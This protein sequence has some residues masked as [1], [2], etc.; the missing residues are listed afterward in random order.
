MSEK[1][2]QVC[3]HVRTIE[4]TEVTGKTH[5]FIRALPPEAGDCEVCRKLLAFPALLET[6]EALADRLAVN[7]GTLPLGVVQMRGW[8]DRLQ[9]AIAQAE[10]SDEAPK[11]TIPG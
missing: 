10:P 9:A 8:R 3:P 1:P 7:N 11:Q 6:C 5:V 4:T 2:V